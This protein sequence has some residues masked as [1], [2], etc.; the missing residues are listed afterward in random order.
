MSR[1]FLPRDVY[2]DVMCEETTPEIQ[3]TNLAKVVL[4]LK[5][6]A[7]DDVIRYVRCHVTFEPVFCF[8]RAARSLVMS[9]ARYSLICQAHIAGI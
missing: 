9:E 4:Y 7:I 2:D 6:M 3:R 8:K 5:S 1:D